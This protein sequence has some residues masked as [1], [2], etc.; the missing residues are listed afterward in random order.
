MA[1][2]F[3]RTRVVKRLSPEQPGALKLARRYGDAL[4]CVRYRHDSEKRHRYTT[5]EL[6]VEQAPIIRRQPSLDAIVAVQIPFGDTARQRRAK[7]LGAR[8]DSKARI[9][10]M[11]RSTAKQL[12]LLNHVLET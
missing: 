8:W 4:V 3:E 5:V 6:V 11:R 9:W 7:A 10:Y 2:A 1:S 12:N